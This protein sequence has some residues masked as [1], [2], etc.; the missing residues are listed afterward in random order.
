MNVGGHFVA[1]LDYRLAPEHRCPAAQDDCERGALAWLEFLRRQYPGIRVAI[2]GESAGAHLA[3][4][5]AIRLRR[6]HNQRFDSALLTYG[7]Y[8][9]VNAVPSRDIADSY[10]GAMDSR[11]CDFMAKTYLKDARQAR[12]PDVSP[13]RAPLSTLRDMPPALFLCAGLDPL[14]DD[15]VL[16][17]NRWIRAGNAAWLALYEEAVHGFDVYQGTHAQHLYQLQLEFLADTLNPQPG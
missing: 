15:S 5:T 3:V 14:L 7:M 16:L 12:D 17:H 11:F 10:P 9:F 8:D 1:S 6:R 4:V 13:L 2:T